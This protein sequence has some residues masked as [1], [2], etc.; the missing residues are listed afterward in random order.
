MVASIED[1]FSSFVFFYGLDGLQYFAASVS[2]P[3][4]QQLVNAH[5]RH[6]V[7]ALYLEGVIYPLSPHRVRSTMDPCPVISPWTRDPR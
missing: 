1:T 4:E 6:L 3:V 7:V 5:E 2:S